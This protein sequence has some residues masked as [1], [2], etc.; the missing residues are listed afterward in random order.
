MGFFRR[1]RVRNV[2]ESDSETNL[3]WVRPGFM[4][5]GAKKF[6][7]S[8]LIFLIFLKPVVLISELSSYLDE[9]LV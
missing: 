8:S 5:L 1:F 7:D 2:S 9:I 3:L 4:F 6:S